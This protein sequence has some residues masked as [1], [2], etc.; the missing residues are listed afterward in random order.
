VGRVK[1]LLREHG[2]PPGT[3]KNF[4]PAFDSPRL[5]EFRPAEGHTG[6]RILPSG[7]GAREEFYAE[8]VARARLQA[9]H[10]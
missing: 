6:A 1:V 2:G 10:R 5:H 9:T 8:G 7:T 4:S 3:Q